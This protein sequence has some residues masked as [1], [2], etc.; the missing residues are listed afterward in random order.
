MISTPVAIGNGTWDVKRVLGET[1]VH[2]G[3]SAFFV[4]PART[5]VYFQA[6]DGCGK[7]VQ[8]MR[9]WSTLQPGENASCVGCHE[10]QNSAPPGQGYGSTLAMKGQR[11]KLARVYGPARGFSLAREAVRSL[12]GGEWSQGNG[13][14]NLPLSMARGATHGFRR[15]GACGET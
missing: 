8:T 7:A 5:L 4:V 9:G 14:V 6:I 10:S 1:P 2:E 13:P 15:V 3:G 12:S 11:L